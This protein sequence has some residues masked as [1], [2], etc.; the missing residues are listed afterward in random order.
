[1]GPLI[2]EITALQGI[3][4]EFVRLHQRI[5]MHH[6]VQIYNPQ[7]RK[8][9]RRYEL[10]DGQGPPATRAAQSGPRSPTRLE[11]VCHQSG[12]DRVYINHKEHYV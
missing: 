1:M 4:H 2:E 11:W 9:E 3:D 7:A 12:T 5:R 8:A 6:N 10:A